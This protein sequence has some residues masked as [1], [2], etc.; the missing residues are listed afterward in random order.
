VHAVDT[1]FFN[2]RSDRERQAYT[3]IMDRVF[4]NTKEFDPHLLDK[5]SIDSEVNSIWQALGWE[6]FVLVQEVG[7]RPTIIQFLCT[8]QEDAS[9]IS[10]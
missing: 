5:T 2:L 3:L 9:G 8:L 1:T 7:S 10:F 4:A 6:D